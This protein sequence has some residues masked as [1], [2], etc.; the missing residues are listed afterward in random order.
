MT[1]AFW[2][3][4]VN[5]FNPVGVVRSE[6]VERFFVDREEQDPTR[7]RL[8]Q[9]QIRL[10]N[11]LGQPQPYTALLTGHVGSGKSSELMRLGQGLVDDYFVVWFDAE[12]SLSTETANHFDVL[13]G[14]GVA[15]H[16]AAREA[17]LKPNDRLIEALLES[18]STF[19][20][21][22][23][24]RSDFILK[25][26]DVIKQ[27]FA[28]A[29]IAGAGA[30]GGPPAAIVAGAAV[31]GVD[32]ILKATRLELKVNDEL[33]RTLELPPNRLEIMGALNDVISD[34]SQKAKKPLLIIMDGLDK[35]SAVRASKL[36]AESTLLAEPACALVYAA[37]I[38][39]YHRL[40]GR[41]V[42]RIF[43]DYWMLSNPTLHRR[44]PV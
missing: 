5:D 10:Q 40:M 16:A 32:R 15:V 14:M 18:L 29:L 13:V 36:F 39:F 41:Q 4:I 20:Q 33:V 17:G 37:P 1:Q 30:V 25:L 19:V 34:A 28:V 27:V 26:S 11:S 38:E 31:V 8:R 3:P 35:V 42:T 2:R 23:T 21:K 24:D 9:L 12:T 22:H 6:D 43:N 44:P 7:S